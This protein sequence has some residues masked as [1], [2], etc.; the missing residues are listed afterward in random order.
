VSVSIDRID[1]LLSPVLDRC[2]VTHQI[3]CCAVGLGLG[4]CFDLNAPIRLMHRFEPDRLRHAFG[5]Q[6]VQGSPVS[7]CCGG[8]RI[9]QPTLGRR[10][11]FAC[12]PRRRPH[13]W[14]HD[15]A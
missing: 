2:D 10:L 6:S 13:I 4:V 5:P 15:E 11:L 3:R 12:F 1:P 8:G 9:G 14:S 7:I